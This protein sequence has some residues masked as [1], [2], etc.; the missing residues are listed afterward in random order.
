MLATAALITLCLVT[1]NQAPAP[2]SV[3]L[4]PLDARPGVE[5]DVADQ[6]T[7]L[8]AAQLAKRA[9]LRVLTIADVESVLARDKLA[10]AAGC[11]TASCW[12]ELA[13][14]LNTDEV[15]Q[16]SV[17]RLGVALIL[18]LSRIKV[19]TGEVVHRVA[20]TITPADASLLILRIPYAA[21]TL[22]P[23]THQARVG[24]G[25]LVGSLGLVAAAGTVAGVMAAL[26][27]LAVVGVWAADLSLGRNRHLVTQTQ[28]ML[29]NVLGVGALGAVLVGALVAGLAGTG[30]VV[31]GVLP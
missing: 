31:A 30:A 22:Y 13:G 7:V 8:L 27:G 3:L 5:K 1:P 25:I 28:G 4:L 2:V 6:V 24:R 18:S 16:G 11:D 17:G 9:E 20:D 14:A 21:R 12:T 23:P 26:T 19:R 29:L 15:I 10:Q